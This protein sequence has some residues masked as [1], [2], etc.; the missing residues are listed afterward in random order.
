MLFFIVQMVGEG[1]AVALQSGSGDLRDNG[2]AFR[3][4]IKQ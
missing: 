2:I 4:F 1:K 3:D